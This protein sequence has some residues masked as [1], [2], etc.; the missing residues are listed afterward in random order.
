MEGLRVRKAYERAAADHGI[1]WAGRTYDQDDWYDASAANRALSAANA[2]LNG[3]CHAA[4]VS[5]GYSAAL[6]FIHVGKM[7]SFV[8]DV[9]DFYKTE[10]TVPVAFGLATTVT[11]DLEK[12]VRQACRAAFHKAQLMNRILPDI[13]EVLGA[14]NDP[15]EDASEHE[16]RAI[17]LADGGTPGNLP[18]ESKLPSPG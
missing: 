9:A 10:I 16:G 18:G 15:G 8:Y 14:S 7:L 1:P 13:Q 6:G 3:V 12:A 17:S 5:A 2:C 11:R 4:I